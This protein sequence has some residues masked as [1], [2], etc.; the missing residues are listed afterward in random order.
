M[1]QKNNLKYIIYNDKKVGTLIVDLVVDGKVI[2]EVKALAGNIPEIFKHQV[3]SYL[4][5]SKLSIG[6]LVNFGNKS[7]QIKRVMF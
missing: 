4:K 1:K 5:A 3:L 7:C 2:V 6:L